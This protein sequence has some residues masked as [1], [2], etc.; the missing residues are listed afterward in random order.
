MTDLFDNK[1]VCGKCNIKMEPVNISKDGFILRAL[2][3]KEC[4]T[5]IIHPKDEQEYKDFTNIKNKEFSVRLRFVGNS[6]AV[7][8]P[9]EIVNYMKEQEKIMDDMVRLCFEEFGKISLNFSPNNH[10]NF[11]I[12]EKINKVEKNRFLSE[13]I[14]SKKI[15]NKEDLI[16]H[17]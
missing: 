10:N 11:P 1:I 17:G 2:F 3:C 6:Y 16:K 5:T 12:E 9:K 15:I 14:D 13:S 8:I 7:S 4:K